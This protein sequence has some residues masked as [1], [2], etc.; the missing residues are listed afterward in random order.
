MMRVLNIPTSVT[1]PMAVI[2]LNAPL[3]VML[4]APAAH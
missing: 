4:L 2:V 3:V 1:I